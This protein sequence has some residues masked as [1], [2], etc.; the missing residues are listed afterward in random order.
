[1]KDN[2]RKVIEKDGAVIA[3]GVYDE[4]VGFERILIFENNPDFSMAARR[5]RDFR[6][7][8]YRIGK[9]VFVGHG[10]SGNLGNEWGMVDI[11][12]LT[13]KLDSDKDKMFEEIRLTLARDAEV[14]IRMCNVADGDK[15][16]R[17]LQGLA[18]RF[19]APVS[20]TPFIYI[21]IPY[22]WKWIT[23]PPT[24]GPV[25]PPGYPNPSPSIS[26]PI[27]IGVDPDE[28]E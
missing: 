15:G 26:E 12:D 1:M 24:K 27:P 16:E 7:R 4:V 20:G 9:L 28:Q 2:A 19:G 21:P 3:A 11:D 22:P 13:F 6:T 25:P 17:F 14:T 5:V 23:K 10:F 18:D 8:G